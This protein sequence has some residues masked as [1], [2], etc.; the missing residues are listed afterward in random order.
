MSITEIQVLVAIDEC[1]NVD[2]INYAP[3]N[4][5]QQLKTDNF[6]KEKRD[7]KKR[8]WQL[9]YLKASVPVPSTPIINA[10]VKKF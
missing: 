9:S 7:D 4:L 2:C 8:I 10:E 3:Y 5:Q 6:I 1:G